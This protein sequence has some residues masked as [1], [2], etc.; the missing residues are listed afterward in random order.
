MGGEDA[1]KSLEQFIKPADDLIISDKGAF[2]LNSKD[3]ILAMKPGGAVEEYVKSTGG[4][5]GKGGNVTININGGDEARVFE[6]VKKAMKSA[7]VVTQGG[8]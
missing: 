5:M 1:S 8:L 2:R 4:G 3:D 6:V 7:G